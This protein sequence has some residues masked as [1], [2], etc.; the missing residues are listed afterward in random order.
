MATVTLAQHIEGFPTAG[1]KR[2]YAALLPSG[3]GGDGIFKGERAAEAAGVAGARRARVPASSAR[4]A[5]GTN[6][7]AVVARACAPGVQRGQVVFVWKNQG[8]LHENASQERVITLEALNALL[9]DPKYYVTGGFAN[10]PETKYVKALDGTP[11]SIDLTHKDVEADDTHPINRWNLDGIVQVEADVDETE[12][13]GYTPVSARNSGAICNVAVCGPCELTVCHLPSLHDTLQQ[14]PSSEPAAVRAAPHVHVK[15]RRVLD[16]IYVILAATKVKEGE[17]KLS[18]NVVSLS[19]IETQLLSKV[20][21][22]DQEAI[23]FR[24]WKLGVV[25][26]TA[27][28]NPRAPQLMVA[29]C[30][31]PLLPLLKNMD[32]N[33]PVFANDPPVFFDTSMG[34]EAKLKRRV[35]L[36]SATKANTSQSQ[37]ADVMLQLRV[38]QTQVED[39]AAEIEELRERLDNLPNLNEQLEKINSEE[40][41]SLKALVQQQAEKN[42]LQDNALKEQGEKNALQ[43][44]ALKEQ[45]EKNNRQDETDKQI[46]KALDKLTR[47]LDGRLDK[48]EADDK[49]GELRNALAV[50]SKNN[51]NPADAEDEADKLAKELI[52]ARDRLRDLYPK[53]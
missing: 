8:R 35:S 20:D 50:R 23:I 11:T 16:R 13:V 15:P 31:R 30:P 32:G 25:L 27:F 34:A 38:L 47:T 28:G 4:P 40:L 37:Y 10:K 2:S 19:N 41:N 43:D 51:T 3:G 53:S 39:Q 12:T 42:A 7:T 21:K 52:D 6:E 45:D 46:V 48:L 29:V 9:E 49:L 1:Q 5:R 33:V 24:V 17:F 44:N 26:D 18:Y 36:S 22:F 14:V